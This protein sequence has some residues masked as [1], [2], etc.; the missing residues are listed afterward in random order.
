MGYVKGLMGG[1]GGV[2][3]MLGYVRR[4]I[5]GLWK[6][7]FVV[8]RINCWKEVQVLYYLVSFVELVG[9]GGE[10]EVERLEDVQKKGEEEGKVRE[11]I[12]GFLKN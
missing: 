5:M 8:V 6:T 10:I 7:R 3:E 2:K 4:W 12:E 9:E 1:I 11:V